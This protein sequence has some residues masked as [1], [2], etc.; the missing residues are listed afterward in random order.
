MRCALVLGLVP[1]VGEEPAQQPIAFE[2]GGDGGGFVGL[3]GLRVVSGAEVDG[4]ARELIREA[5]YG[6]AFGHALGHGIGLATHELPRLAA[7]AETVLTDGMVFTLEPGVYL[8]GWGGVRIEDDVV[9]E[10]GAARTFTEM[11]E[12]K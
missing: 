8:P 12:I 7:N 2:Q 5:G 6:A 1:P 11:G 10:G 9:L 4:A 3:V